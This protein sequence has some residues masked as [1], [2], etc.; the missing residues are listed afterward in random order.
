MTGS[1]LAQ[2]TTAVWASAM[3]RL[4]FSGNTLSGNGLNGANIP[5]EQVTADWTW[6][7]IGMPYVLRSGPG[8]TVANGATLT[9]EP[10]IIVKGLIYGLVVADTGRLMARG[11]ASEPIVFT[12]L[13]DD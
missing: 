12:S 10:G 1:T 5:G 4:T 8:V 2:N 9:L 7:K 3:S 13:K 11:T 6:K